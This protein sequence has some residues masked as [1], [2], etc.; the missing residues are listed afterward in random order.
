MDKDKKWAS[1]ICLHSDN[2]VKVFLSREVTVQEEFKS[3]LCDLI[4]L[5]EKEGITGHLSL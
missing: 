2:K 5:G 3:D 1:F 4:G